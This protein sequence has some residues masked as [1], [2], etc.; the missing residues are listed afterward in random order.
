M[1][2]TIDANEMGGKLIDKISNAIDVVFDPQ[3]LKKGQRTFSK[4]FFTELANRDDLS[5]EEKMAMIQEYRFL[6]FKNK[7]IYKIIFGAEKYLLDTAMPEKIDDSWIAV[8]WDKAGVIL[9]EELQEI[10]SKVLAQEAN[11]PNSISKRLLHNLSL[12][13]LEDARNF[14]NIG[15]FCFDDKRYDL[16]HPIIYIREHPGAYKKSG[17]TTKILKELELFSLIE[18]NYDTGFAFNNRQLLT[19][20]GYSI[21]VK[22]KR[23]NVGNVKLTED[24]QRLY[25]I[26][27]KQRKEQIFAYTIE[28]LEYKN[29]S[30]KFLEN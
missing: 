29:C 6:L 14:E 17:I 10:W 11:R 30:I 27:E 5:I 23:I 9:D 21:E 2:I 28:N 13:S 22:A 18:T 7:N 16:A 15:R 20:M 26:I 19:Y 8:F 12:M 4:I 25:K 3:G 1:E 24:G